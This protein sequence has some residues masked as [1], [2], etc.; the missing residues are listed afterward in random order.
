MTDDSTMLFQRKG[1]Q[2]AVLQNTLTPVVKNSLLE[3]ICDLAV[4]SVNERRIEERREKGVFWLI[5]GIWDVDAWNERMQG[6]EC[7]RNRDA[8]EKRQHCVNRVGVK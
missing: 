4:R 6:D 5:V 8:T 7:E 1:E 2:E 3:G